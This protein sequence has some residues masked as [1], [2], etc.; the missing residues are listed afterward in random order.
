VEYMEYVSFPS[1]IDYTFTL[2]VSESVF[3]VVYTLKC[4]FYNTVGTPS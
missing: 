1:V 2:F 4:V 3:I